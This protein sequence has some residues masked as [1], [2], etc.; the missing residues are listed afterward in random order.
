MLT[1]T[2]TLLFAMS[3][4]VW[5]LL[6]RRD[7]EI[8]RS[9]KEGLQLTAWSGSR[10][11]S[12]KDTLNGRA[13][14]RVLFGCILMYFVTHTPFICAFVVSQ[15]ARHPHSP[16]TLSH[17]QVR[18]M[19]D[20]VVL[21]CRLNFAGNFFVYLVT[22]TRFRRHAVF[23]IGQVMRRKAVIFPEHLSAQARFLRQEPST[24]R[25]DANLL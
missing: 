14:N 13:S 7:R 15:L 6:R 1:I 4:T 24:A 10:Q 17:D 19:W 3:C 5:V 25:N 11:S 8:Q 21:F 23:L 12:K 9:V 2:L 18:Q 20:V 22:S 16:V